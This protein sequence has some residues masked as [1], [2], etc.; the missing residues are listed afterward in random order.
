MCSMKSSGTPSGA[1]ELLYPPERKIEIGVSLLASPP[2][3]ILP[4]YGFT[5]GHE[6][7]PHCV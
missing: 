4:G 5:D 2:P 6:I 1:C 7:F 3:C